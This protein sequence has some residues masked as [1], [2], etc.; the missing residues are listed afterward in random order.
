VRVY[1]LPPDGGAAAS[2]EVANVSVGGIAGASDITKPL[3]TCGTTCRQTNLTLTGGAIVN[4]DVLGPDGGRATFVVPDLPA[5]SGASLL[6]AMQ[7][8]MHQLHTYEVSELLSSGL[9]TIRST[10]RA[11]APDRTTWS[12]GGE[13]ETIFIGTT[14]YSRDAPGQPWATQT[15]LPVDTVPS[16]VWDYFAP[17]SD[18]RIAGH[19]RVDGVPTTEV[20]AFGN[21]QATAIW[22]RFWVDAGGFVRRV[23]MTAAGHFMVDN[24][25]ALNGNVVITAP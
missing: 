25:V 15:G 11:A 18:A 20:S 24:Y 17:L 16:F 3:V 13:S 23:Q 7:Q 9:T 22:F 1:L 19:A 6:L 14:E 2:A 21:K 5:A 12:V 8:H 10:Y 4:V